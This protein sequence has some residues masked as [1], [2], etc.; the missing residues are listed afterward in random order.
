MLSKALLTVGVLGAGVLAAPGYTPKPYGKQIAV[1]AN[2]GLRIDSKFSQG[3]LAH[4]ISSS[5]T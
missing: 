2:V 1:D 3:A 5:M 4:R